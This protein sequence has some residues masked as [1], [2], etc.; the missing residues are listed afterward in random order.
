[1]ERQFKERLIG[2]AV[3]VAAAVVMVPEIFS[4]PGSRPEHLAGEGATLPGQLQTYRIDLQP[5]Q[6]MAPRT[7]PAVEAPADRPQDES[8]VLTSDK[9]E[10]GTA[11][12]RSDIAAV[13]GSQAVPSV[14]GA[15][16]P[17]KPTSSKPEVAGA[18]PV[19]RPASGDWVVQIGSFS[20]REKAQQI[21]DGLKA[22]GHPALVTPVK[23]GGKT[24]YRVRVGTM[25]E[26]SAADSTLRKLQA[27]YPGASV[28]PA[29]R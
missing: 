24:L 10:P 20:A 17:A 3:L 29:S 8:S 13:Q 15:D 1:M 6:P 16:T 11:A 9:T 28:V 23:I 14:G 19:S 26:R 2:A 4:G 27:A 25:T 12:S 22:E 7:E 21:A 5:V 18:A